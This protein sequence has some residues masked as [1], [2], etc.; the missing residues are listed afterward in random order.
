[1]TVVRNGV[2]IINEYGWLPANGFA[3]EMMIRIAGIFIDCLSPQAT[4]DAFGAEA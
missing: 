2:T 4:G 1:M 3:D